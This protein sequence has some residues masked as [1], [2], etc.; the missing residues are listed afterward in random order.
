MQ[1]TNNKY[2]IRG[3]MRK[4]NVLKKKRVVTWCKSKLTNPW[5]TNFVALVCM[6]YFAGCL[7]LFQVNASFLS[8]GISFVWEVLSHYGSFTVKSDN[9][10]VA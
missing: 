5:E 1:L 7:V 4:C 3:E 2:D 10:I 9:E 8:L 6:V